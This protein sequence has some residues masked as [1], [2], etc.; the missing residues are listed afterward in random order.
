[1][2]DLSEKKLGQYQIVVLIGRGGMAS[3]Y[4]AYQPN[5][6]RFVALKV[7]PRH[8]AAD[9]DFVARFRTEAKVIANLEHP[10]IVPVYDF[11]ESDGYTFLV[12]RFIDRE[13]L[14]SL[15]Q[16]KPLPFSQILDL[17]GQIASALDYAY[18]RG[19]IH[20]DV[21]PGNV[22]LDEH[23]NCLLSDFGLAKVLINSS[24]LTASGAFLGTPTYASPE[25]CLGRT[26]IDQRSDVYSLGVMLYEMVTGQPPFDADTPMGIAI[27]H[28]HYPLP[29]PRT[30]NPDLP[31]S[32]EQVI[33]KALTK[34][35]DERYATAGEL[36]Q[37]LG[38][39]V[40]ESQ[41]YRS[42]LIASPS[43]LGSAEISPSSG[44]ATAQPRRFLKWVWLVVGV[45]VLSLLLVFVSGSRW[46]MSASNLHDKDTQEA[47]VPSIEYPTPLPTPV[48]EKPTEIPETELLAASPTSLPVASPTLDAS[49]IPECEKLGQTWV[50]P[51][52]GMTMLCVPAGPFLMGSDEN[53]RYRDDEIPQRT[54]HLDA[55]WIDQTEVTNAMF[56]AFVNETG[57][58][59]DAENQ[60]WSYAYVPGTG[61]QQQAAADWLHPL[62]S[63]SSIEGLDDHPVV[64]VSWN[65]AQAYCRWAERQLPTEAQWEK[66]AR[67][68]DG[69][70]YPWGDE[71]YCAYGNF[72]DQT[73]SNSYVM[74]AVRGCDGFS[75]TAPVGHF[76][77]GA[78]PYGAMDMSG[79]VWEWA[80]D[81]YLANYYRNAPDENPLG[82]STGTRRAIR[83][84]FWYY[85][86]WDVRAASRGWNP[87][88]FTWHL[89]G[90]RCALGQ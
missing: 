80:A 72:D 39:A 79:N 55:Y 31:E 62:G 59:T 25:Q 32:V 85:N 28:I 71:F 88:D 84:G 12:M 35:P 54:V 15:L 60:R 33:L 10:N 47:V 1:V 17:I 11:G 52:D 5:M 40:R 7:L 48:V 37:A 65:D 30:V 3:V 82:P 27:K 78:S 70:K 73:L 42:Q 75:P 14:G 64:R 45:A 2:E 26:D 23:G 38:D 61:W 9:P 43:P 13:S 76:P 63:D 49:V 18:S 90:F 4:K 6:E 66:A 36:S 67:G 69:R 22:L 21:K 46:L 86:S 83:G 74:S 8:L 34:D 20:R 68:E 81:W 41:T 58:Q 77:D 44:V 19:V 89:I 51:V 53:D 56:A 50:S 57:Y 24:N 16:G 87:P 29:S